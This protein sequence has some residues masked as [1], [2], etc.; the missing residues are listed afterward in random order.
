[1]TSPT[2]RV[3]VL[4]PVHNAGEYLAPALA[5]L[6]W[7]T[8]ADWEAICVDDGSTDGSPEV[9][10]AFARADP[11]FR[12]VRQ[13]KA[14][15]VAALNRGLADVRGE[16]I[17]R[18]DGDD[19]ATPDRFAKQ[20]AFAEA[21]PECVAF[22]AAVRLVDP[23]GAP[24]GAMGYP[25]DHDA[26]EHNLLTS[27]GG[28]IAHPTLFVRRDAV[29]A[30]GPY[31]HEYETVQDADFLLRL[32]RVGRLSNLPDELLLYR[33]HPKNYCRVHHAS[34]RRQM[35][36]LLEAAHDERGLALPADLARRLERPPRTSPLV[37]KWARRAARSGYLR[38]AA[39][40][41]AQQA[42]AKPLSVYTARV[43]VEVGLRSLAALATGRRGEPLRLPDWRLWD[44]SP[45]GE[46]N[47]RAA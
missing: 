26:I 30:A 4:L 18:M 19:L 16:W 31:R 38:T 8:F 12:V 27:G 39:R 3:S 22:G 13:E 17:A 28:T 29:E 9:L 5:S 20:V 41:A 36:E 6:R 11:R 7:Q 23:T 46:A 1:V 10:A 15:L 43:A 14:G 42:A 44:A 2:P 33:Q 32:A 35:R 45:E 47:A 34:I 21:H 25:D 37:G 24:L 40:L